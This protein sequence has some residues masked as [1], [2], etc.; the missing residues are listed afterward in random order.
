VAPRLPTAFIEY[1]CDYYDDWIIAGNFESNI[2][3][4]RT[5]KPTSYSVAQQQ[6]TA[7]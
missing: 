4:K 7:I 1:L 3:A 2:F 5:N 6:T